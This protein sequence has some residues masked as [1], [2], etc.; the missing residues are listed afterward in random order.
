MD[1]SIKQDI[2][3]DVIKCLCNWYKKHYGAILEKVHHVD[4]R[5][6]EGGSLRIQGW[7][8][9]EDLWNNALEY[10]GFDMSFQ[11]DKKNRIFVISVWV[12]DPFMLRIPSD[13]K[14]NIPGFDDYWKGNVGP[15]KDND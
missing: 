1:Y 14:P 5:F 3:K 11:L 6:V 15:F 7:I 12:I 2:N 4:T 9:E 10:D 8:T 13:F